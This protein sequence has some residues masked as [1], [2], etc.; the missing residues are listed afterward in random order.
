MTRAD[1]LTKRHG[2]EVTMST[3]QSINPGAGPLA[4]AA[5]LGLLTASAAW[6][7]AAGRRGAPAPVA[8]AG[9][10]VPSGIPAHIR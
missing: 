1:H 3:Q 2:R 4:R 6:I 8:G 7:A 10:P 5:R 9:D